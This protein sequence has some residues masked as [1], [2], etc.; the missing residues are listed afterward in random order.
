MAWIYVKKKNSLWNIWSTIVDAYLSDDDG[1]L[2]EVEAYAL[3]CKIEEVKE[4][5]KRTFERIRSGD[6]LYFKDEK[7]LHK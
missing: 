4:Q 1:T 3:E 6:K 2:E 5:N 7:D